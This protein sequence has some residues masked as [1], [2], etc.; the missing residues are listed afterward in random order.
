MKE[1]EMKDLKEGDVI[2]LNDFNNGGNETVFGLVVSF[3][4]IKKE[5]KSDLVGQKPLLKNCVWFNVLK[6]ETNQWTVG[7]EY[8]MTNND[9]S[10]VWGMI[11]LLDKDEVDRFMRD[12][13]L[14]AD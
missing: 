1:I 11:E 6:S 13:M 8:S 12:K 4:K 5:R 10:C 3:D 14:E 9:L 7:K 2:K